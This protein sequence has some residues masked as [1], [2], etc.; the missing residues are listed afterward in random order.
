MQIPTQIASEEEAKNVDSASTGATSSTS[1]AM[2]SNFI[3]NILLAGSLT[4]IWS[5]LNSL[6]IVELVGLFHIKMPGNISAF[7]DFFEVIT[8]IKIYDSEPTVNENFYLP[9]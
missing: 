8:D 9:E 6:Q 5:I 7:T 4:Q 1:S 3:I 2:G